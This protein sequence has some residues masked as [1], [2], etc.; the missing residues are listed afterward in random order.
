VNGE[1]GMGN[2]KWGEQS[3]KLKVSIY[4]GRVSHYILLNG[5]LLGIK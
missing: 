5:Q 4:R 3:F 1:W 2:G